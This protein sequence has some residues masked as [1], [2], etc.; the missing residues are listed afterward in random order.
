MW[1]Y[2]PS[3]HR[4][5][6]HPPVGCQ[7]EQR[8]SVDPANGLLLGLLAFQNNFIDREALLAALSDWDA[9]KATPLGRILIGRGAS[10][11][12]L[13][14]CWSRWRVSTWSCTAAIRRRSL[15]A[16][17]VRESTRDVLASVDAPGVLATLTHVGSGPAD[18]GGDAGR[19][20]S[21]NMGTTTREGHRFRILRPHA[22]GGLG[23]VYV[24]LDS[25]LNREVAL[26]ADP[27]PPRRRP[28]QS[29]AVPH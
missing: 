11:S 10:T 26:E 7:P 6:D 9:D 25:E 5:P 2:P 8:S 27:G 4:L 20:A 3:A 23:A 29:P 18:A 21:D 24:A 13:T 16:L 1:C 17:A 19:S 12:R 14:P 22:R 28:D 15:A